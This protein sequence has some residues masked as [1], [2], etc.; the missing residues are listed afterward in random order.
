MIA[1][2]AWGSLKRRARGRLP[3]FAICAL[4]AF[5]GVVLDRILDFGL[6]E[7]RSDLIV[8]L[9]VQGIISFFVGGVV[10]GSGAWILTD[11]VLPGATERGLGGGP[12]LLFVCLLWTAT[13]VTRGKLVPPS[14]D[15]IRIEA[16]EVVVS[17]A[18]DLIEQ[19]RDRAAPR[20]PAWQPWT[21]RCPSSYGRW[22][23]CAM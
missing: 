12:L 10:I 23:T 8:A 6:E 14:A 5:V 16:P 18:R 15:D 22:V 11:R 13:V 20:G 1:L 4:G 17:V 21:Y 3:L 2:L 7:F 19:Q 9:I